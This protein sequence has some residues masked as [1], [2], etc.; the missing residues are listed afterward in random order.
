MAQQQGVVKGDALQRIASA[1]FIIGAVLLIVF[2]FL[3]P[4]AADP[5]NTQDLLTK[6][7]GQKGLTQLCAL[8]MAVGIWGVMMGTAG[9]YRSITANG[10]A[11]ARLGFYGITVGT[12]IWSVTFGLVAA[13]AALAADWLA[14]SA[15]SKAAAY[16]VAAS[17][18]NVNTSTFTMSI[19]VFWLAIVFLGIGMARSGV[20]PKWLGWVGALLGAVTVVAVG[21][22]QFF[23]G[24]TS[25]LQTLFAVLAIL[26]TI[27]VL[28]VGI[29]VARKAW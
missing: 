18:G 25:N 27:W 1:G 15:A 13:T 2:N 9:V 11:W 10:A 12:A 4:R 14:A 29:W 6:W 19:L 7:G 24:E 8:L 3:L 5:S 26:T 21:I 17:L 22:P 23:A 16:G 20:Y 28:I